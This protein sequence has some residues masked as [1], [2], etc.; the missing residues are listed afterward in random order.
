[1]NPNTLTRFG[2]QVDHFLSEHLFFHNFI[3]IILSIVHLMNLG[4]YD[5]FDPSE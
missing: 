1:M 3:T 2:Q 5:L 4:Q